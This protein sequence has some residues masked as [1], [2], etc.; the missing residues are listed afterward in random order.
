MNKHYEILC[1]PKNGNPEY[2]VGLGSGHK[3]THEDLKDAEQLRDMLAVGS[4]GVATYTIRE[5]VEKHDCG[6]SKLSTSSPH[7][8]RLLKDAKWSRGEI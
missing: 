6:Y 1:Q 2:V 3:Y 7:Y 8:R 5:A 4:A